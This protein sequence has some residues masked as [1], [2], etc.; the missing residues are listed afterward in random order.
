MGSGHKA[1][2]F[3]DLDRL[4]RRGTFPAGDGALLASYAGGDEEAFEALVARHGPMV[5]GVCRRILGP[6]DAE[7]AFQATFLV[8]ARKA[9]QLRDAD[10][11]GPWLYGVA[12]RVAGKARTRAARR[13]HQPLP[14][15]ADRAGHSPEW[16]DVGAIVDAELGRLPA[17]YRDVLVLC[18][19][20]GA[21]AEEAARRLACPLGTVKSRLA[22]GR[23]ALRSRLTGRGIAPAV[24]AAALSSALASPVSAALTR[25]TLAAV[26]SSPGGVAPAVAALTRGAAPSMLS[27]STLTASALIGSLALAALGL[28]AW[29][30]P[31]ASA[32]EA[33]RLPGGGRPAPARSA[34]DQTRD[35]IKT[36]LLAA[37]NYVDSNGSFPPQAIY[38]S[39]GQPKLS[40]R[41]ALLPYLGEQ[42]LYDQ[43]RQDEAWDSPHNLALA[44][45]MPAVF[46]TPHSPA[47]GDDRTRIRGFAGP[48]TLFDGARGVE[49]RNILDGT[50]NTLF[51]AVAR[52]ETPWTRPGELPFA[53]GQPLPKLDDSDPN[54]YLVGMADGAFTYVRRKGDDT[55]LRKII[56]RAGSEVVQWPQP[57]VDPS[58]EHP[59]VGGGLTPLPT[60]PVASESGMMAMMP[61]GAPPAPPELEQRLRRLE[62][63]LDLVLRKLDAMSGTGAPDSDGTATER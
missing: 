6:H 46:R 53:A 21:T 39:D 44:A 18:L 2:G 29:P 62:E 37:H 4:F 38:G 27:K 56:T 43:F 57:V 48:G 51:V 35:N 36:I 24:A 52:D 58:A 25:A 11:L 19:L 45:R 59:A 12:R 49:L 7:D 60:P 3:R 28:T 41:V 31:P 32:Q 33:A 8:L 42:E 22:R 16:L 55:F 50:L 1:V 47:S 61:G 15:V 9:G 63:K 13:R 20:E 17:K 54:G 14:E 10:R 40:W 5:Q 30:R 34:A 26:A 23:D